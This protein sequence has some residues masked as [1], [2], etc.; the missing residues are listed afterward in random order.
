MVREAMVW[1]SSVAAAAAAVAAA[2]IEALLWRYSG[3]VE[4]QQRQR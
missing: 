3:K 1:R 4:Q 2:V